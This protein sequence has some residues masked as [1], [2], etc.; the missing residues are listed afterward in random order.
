MGKHK[1]KVAEVEAKAGPSGSASP[2]QPPASRRVRGKG[3]GVVVGTV[4]PSRLLSVSY[5]GLND[6]VVDSVTGMLNP[7]PKMIRSYENQ[8]S[9]SQGEEGVSLEF[10]FGIEKKKNF[11]EKLSS[12]FPN[13]SAVCKEIGISR[14]TFKNHYEID[15]IF[16]KRV[17]E[18]AE[19]HIDQIEDVRFQVAK[20]KGGVMDRMAVLNSWRGERYQPKTKIEIEHKMTAGEAADRAARLGEVIDAEVV[21]QVH[22]MRTLREKS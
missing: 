18:I 10:L 22:R 12:L 17:D 3:M 16:R 15:K 1:K 13:V 14:H 11:L 19:T 20:R 4:Q 21:E 7:S 8:I 2:A 6:F 5:I 9:G